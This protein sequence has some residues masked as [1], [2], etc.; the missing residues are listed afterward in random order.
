ML[1]LILIWTATSSALRA[2]PWALLGK[3]ASAPSVPWMNALMLSGIAIGS[4]LAPYL[5]V[6]LKNLDPRLPFAVSSLALFAV[7]AMI[8]MVM[9]IAGVNRQPDHA[10]LLAWMPAFL[11]TAGGA[12]LIAAWM[13]GRN[14]AGAA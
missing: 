3:Y 14:R 8:R 1:A 11:W 13:A 5:G 12:L 2:P 9:T 7:A 4:A 10:Q 6:T